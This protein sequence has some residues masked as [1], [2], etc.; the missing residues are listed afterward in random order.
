M[1]CEKNIAAYVGVAIVCVLI[2]VLMEDGLRG[3]LD[4]GVIMINDRL[5]PCFNG[6]WSASMK[7]FEEGGDA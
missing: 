4:F 2:L 5:N 7:N 6:R 3:V 1:V